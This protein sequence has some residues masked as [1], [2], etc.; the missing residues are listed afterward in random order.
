MKKLI[1]V[2]AAA[3]IGIGANAQI[4]VV[5]GVTST[6]TNLSSAVV[7]AKDITQYHVGLAYKLN[8][9]IIG[10][11]PALIYNIKG[12]S[13][14]AAVSS[15]GEYK[16]DFKTG[17]LEVPVQIQLAIPIAGFR[18]YIFAEPFAGYAIT[19]ETTQEV[20]AAAGSSIGSAITGLISGSSNGKTSGDWSNL[21]SRFEYGI[22][23]GAGID[24]FKTLQVSLRYFWNFGQI[25]SDD[26]A[27][28][29]TVNELLKG[30]FDTSVSTIK[31]QKCSGIMATVGIFF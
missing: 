10:V 1:L 16:A 6:S 3:L 13:L 27:T 24:L 2:L 19:N 22:G 18:P 11:Q 8:L 17:F 15:V 31:D 28:T 7:S 5:A 26:S 14:G 4:G 9:G 25:Y 23:L 12:T 29:G 30:Y 20:T 21:S